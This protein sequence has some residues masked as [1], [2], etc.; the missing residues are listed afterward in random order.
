MRAYLAIVVLAFLGLASSITN[1]GIFEE[2]HFTGRFSVGYMLNRS[3]EFPQAVYDTNPSSAAAT[4]DLGIS[5]K[6][7]FA[8]TGGLRISQKNSYQQFAFGYLQA[9]LD[10]S[11][12][13]PDIDVDYACFGFDVYGGLMA[14]RI[15]GQAVMAVERPDGIVWRLERD[16][17]W[18]P[19][20]SIGCRVH[21][22]TA[23][24]RG[25]LGFDLNYHFTRDFLLA[26]GFDNLVPQVGIIIMF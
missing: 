13:L 18:F 20:V 11:Y 7:R 6:R 24:I 15:S 19:G 12:T 10:V 9:R 5:F 3:L 26:K 16:E 21:Y 25:F 8:I 23:T 2:P 22:G 14:S 17:G 4:I 1:A